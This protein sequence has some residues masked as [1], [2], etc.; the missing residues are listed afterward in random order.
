V[1]FTNPCGGVRWKI[2]DDGMIEVEGQG[3]PSVD[4]SSAAYQQMV[5]TWQNFGELFQASASTYGLPVQWVLAVATMETGFLSADI[6][7]QAQAVSPAGAIGVM[8]IM[9]FNA[10]TYGLSDPSELYDPASNIDVG[11]H[12]LSVLNQN[13]SAGGLPG[14][15]ALYNSGK[16]CTTDTSRNQFMLLEDSDY[17]EHVIE[18]NNTALQ[19]GLVSSISTTSYAVLGAALGGALAFAFT[20]TRLKR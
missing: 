10:T 1:D 13:A 5:Q 15:A 19:T 16:L 2:D 17:S 8:Q 7:K 9:P 20:K 11:V 3:Y 18:W 12:L 4:P 6:T 14:I